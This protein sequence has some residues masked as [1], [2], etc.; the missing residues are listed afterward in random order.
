MGMG[1]QTGWGMGGGFL[2]IVLWIALAVLLVLGVRWL[3]YGMPGRLP[4]GQDSE[5]LKTL[6]ERYARGDIDREEFEQKK[7]DLNEP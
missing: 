5:A 1:Y 7:R 2:M 3:I 4:P 6:K